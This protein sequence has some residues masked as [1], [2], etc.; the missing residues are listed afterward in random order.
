M[1]KFANPFLFKLTYNIYIQCEFLNAFIKF[2]T[3]LFP[4]CKISLFFE[5]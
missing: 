1:N 4:L 2:L 3:E 5:I